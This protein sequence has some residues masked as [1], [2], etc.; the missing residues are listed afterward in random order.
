AAALEPARVSLG[1][2]DVPGASGD[3]RAALRASATAA[4][5]FAD[6]PVP[7]LPGLGPARPT[8]RAITAGAGR[9]GIH[10]TRSAIRGFSPVFGPAGRGAH[11]STNHP[12]TWIDTDTATAS[13]TTRDR[14]RPPASTRR[15]RAASVGLAAAVIAERE[16]V[17][18]LAVEI[19]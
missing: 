16:Q 4:E 15:V 7:R 2:R 19:T 11:C 3:E 14:R 18:R 10:S 13:A 1:L 8:S 17:A 9:A 6:C 12:A 5:R